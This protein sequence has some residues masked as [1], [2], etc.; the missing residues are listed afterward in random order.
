MGPAH[1][2]PAAPAA[3]LTAVPAAGTTGLRVSEA[4][5]LH[6]EDVDFTRDDERIAVLGKG[7]RRRTVLL[8]DPE[9]VRLLRRHLRERGYRHGPV[10]R[11]ERGQPA[12]SLRYASLQERFRSTPGPPA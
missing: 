8:D 7:G 4:L 9:T 1:R 2:H 12:T 10:F 5:A 3:R 11:A 6:V